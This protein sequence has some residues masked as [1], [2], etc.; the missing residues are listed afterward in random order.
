MPFIIYD[1]RKLLYVQV[2]LDQ[3]LLH[4]NLVTMGP[5][6]LRG[7]LVTPEKV[8]STRTRSSSHNKQVAA[9][10]GVQQYTICRDN[11]E[12]NGRHIKSTQRTCMKYLQRTLF[13]S[14]HE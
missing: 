14:L 7:S 13:N 8:S 5:V 2:I 10:H 11:P 9:Y 4:Q 1:V 3:N 12:K 6:V